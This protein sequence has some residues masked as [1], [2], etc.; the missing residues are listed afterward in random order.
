MKRS[1][2]SLPSDVESP[3]QSGGKRSASCRRPSRLPA[4]DSK[5]TTGGDVSRPLAVVNGDDLVSISR[6]L[7]DRLKGDNV[8]I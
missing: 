7:H 5:D 3:R 1:R 6:Q 8:T 2:S 4:Q